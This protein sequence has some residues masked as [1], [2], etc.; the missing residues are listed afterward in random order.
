MTFL[1]ERLLKDFYKLN[2]DEKVELFN[3][4]DKEISEK[5]HMPRANFVFEK[6]EFTL[7]AKNI[8]FGNLKD[9]K[10]G[11]EFISRYC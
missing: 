11:Y 4:F 2:D 6:K 9:V 1:L 8:Y 3:Q 5:L 10:S 7:D